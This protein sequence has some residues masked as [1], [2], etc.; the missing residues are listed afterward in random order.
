MTK[1]KKEV[2]QE[3]IEQ[4]ENVPLIRKSFGNITINSMPVSRAKTREHSTKI[5]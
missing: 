4:V 1:K 5:I 2:K 3:E